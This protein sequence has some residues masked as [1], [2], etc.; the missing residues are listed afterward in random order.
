MSLHRHVGTL[1]WCG[2]QTNRVIDI[3]TLKQVAN[4]RFSHDNLFHTLPGL[5]QIETSVYRADADILAPFTRK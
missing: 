4:N 3:T 5:M 1:M 2:E